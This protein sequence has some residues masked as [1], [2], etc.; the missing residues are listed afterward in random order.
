MAPRRN[1]EASVGSRSRPSEALIATSQA[2]AAEIWKVSRDDRRR[3]SNE[4]GIDAASVNAQSQMCVS[5]RI[6]ISSLEGVEDFV[7]QGCVEV[8]G[9]P[10][11]PLVQVERVAHPL[12]SRKRH[13]AGKRLARLGNDDLLA[14]RDAGEETREAR[15]RLVDVHGRRLHGDESRLTP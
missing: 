2:L 3:E 13:Q 11:P 8:W 10:N 6:R 14:L 1:V 7:R 9:N 12:W 5:R 15:L 4:P